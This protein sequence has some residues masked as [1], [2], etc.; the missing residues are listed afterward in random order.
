MNKELEIAQSSFE[1]TQSN[2]NGIITNVHN[3]SDRIFINH[4]IN[5]VISK[6]YENTQEIYKDYASLSF[7]DD[8]LRSMQEVSNY[9]IYVENPTLLDNSFIVKATKEIQNEEWYNIAIRLRGQ[10]FWT[11]Q[12]DILTKKKYLCIIRSLWDSVQG[13]FLGVLVINVNQDI[14]TERLSSKLYNIILLVNNDTYFKCINDESADYKLEQIRE[15]IENYDFTKPKIISFKNERHKNGLLCYKF[16]PANTNNLNMK[17]IFIIP[18]KNLLGVS[19]KILIVSVIL[20][21]SLGLLTILLLRLFKAYIDER[22]N[23]IQTGIKSV[24]S[25]NFAIVPTIGGNDEF[26]DIYHSLYEMSKNIKNLI[27]QVYAQ[28]L[29]KE[30]LASRQN[31]IR[32]KMLS[33]QINPHFLFNTLETIRMKSLATGD[34]EVANMLKQLAALLRYNLNITGKPVCFYDEL[35]AVQNYLSIQ[36]VRFGQRISHDI[37][38]LCDVRQIQVLPLLIQ[39]LIENSFSHGLEDTAEN[40]FIYVLCEIVKD[41][42]NADELLRISVKDNGCGIENEKLMELQRSLEDYVMDDEHNS[43]GIFNVNSR[44]KLFYGPQYGLKIK[45]EVGKGTTVTLEL[46]VGNIKE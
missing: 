21:I 7:V 4:Q 12:E 40:G 38:I 43:I 42:E 26:Q 9:R 28:N 23:K 30:Q 46:P 31:T 3:F 14:F 10:I 29:E 36:Q 32:F 25:N 20:L 13:K 16:S 6:K 41:K 24:V 11:Y 39:P 2:L 27:N 19:I 5:N 45:S 17:I 37:M 15:L 22:V 35:N 1:I 44:I 34:R 18:F 8:Y 33:T